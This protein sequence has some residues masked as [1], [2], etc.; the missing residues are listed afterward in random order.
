M[1][2]HHGFTREVTVKYTGALRARW[3]VGWRL[4][5]VDG[6]TQGSKGP[7][8]AALLA[9]ASPEAQLDP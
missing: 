3:G 6:N 8:R 1:C 4:E 9:P 2:G 5:G 7:S